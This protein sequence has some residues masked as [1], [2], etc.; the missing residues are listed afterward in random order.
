MLICPLFAIGVNMMRVIRLLPVAFIFTGLVTFVDRGFN[1]E[2]RKLASIRDQFTSAV[3][4]AK[5]RVGAVSW[6][7]ISDAQM[8]QNFEMGNINTVTQSLQG[9]VRPGEVT[10]MDVLDSECNLV[11]RVPQ[12]GKPV[13]ELCQTVKLGKPAL[14]WQVNDQNEAVLV[15]VVS[16]AMAGKMIFV[17]SQLVFDHGWLSLHPGLAVLQSNRDIAINSPGSGAVLWKEGK[18]PDGRFALQLSV[19][20]WIYRVMPELTGLALAPRRESFWVLFGALG[21]VIVLVL[22]QI[23]A[24]SRK[25]E[26]ERASLEAWIREHQ[27]LKSQ[28]SGQENAPVM[29]WKEIVSTARALISSKDEQRGHQLRLM[30]ERVEKVTKR[31]RERDLEIAELENKLAGMSD[32][33]SLQEQLQHT[34]TSFLRQISQ[35][36]EVCENIYDVATSGLTQ[37]AKSLHAFC[38]RWKE[39]LSQGTSR[40]MAARKFFRHLV[41]SKGSIPGWSKLDEDM[42]ELDQLTASTLDQSLN[43]AMLARQVVSDCESA[44]KLAALWR[45]IACRDRAEKTSEWVNCLLAAQKLVSADDK[46]QAMRFEMLPQLGSPEDM[47]PAVSNAGLIS[48]FFHLY[49]AL[50]YDA[51]VAA[52]TLP[53]VVRQKRFKDQA[54][55]ILSLP[56]RQAGQIPE[57][58]SRQMLY[59][60]DL[61]KQILSGC[62]LKVSV[63]PPTVAGYPV[64]LTWSLP[65][66]VT[67]VVVEHE[68]TV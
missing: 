9:Y 56:A 36:R 5:G 15:S 12:G 53:M 49:L 46:F 60:V 64:G 62:G 68:V 28:A 7:A 31:L 59:H 30:H 16:R 20:G 26:L 32:L 24:G 4:D 14:F 10:Q 58:P 40:E 3:S 66:K 42:R 38:A 2:M 29:A 18:L 55:I 21:I 45:G 61:A 43:T 54:T 8:Q 34:T 23:A 27:L 6:A 25:D 65:Q 63:L 51:D 48:G 39:G 52:I 50:L 22:T 33:A 1:D 19:D 35:M 67:Q 41:E 13:A 37:Q 44:A 11:A 57:S 17:A 47:Y